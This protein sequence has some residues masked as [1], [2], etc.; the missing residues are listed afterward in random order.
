MPSLLSPWAQS[1]ADTLVLDLH[2]AV[3]EQW[4][5]WRNRSANKRDVVHIVFFNMLE[6]RSAGTDLVHSVFLKHWL[7]Y[8]YWTA[9]LMIG[10]DCVVFDCICFF[11]SFLALDMLV[12]SHLFINSFFWVNF[13]N[14]RTST[15][16]LPRYRCSLRRYWDD[17]EVARPGQK[18]VVGKP[19]YKGAFGC[20]CKGKPGS[21]RPPW[22][23]LVTCTWEIAWAD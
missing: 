3:P 13:E 16:P 17:H 18:T 2:N 1:G 4:Q 15:V 11:L 9:C 23:C 7:Q 14:S 6:D 8:T 5:Q 10:R 12:L 21:N 20:L 22:A 19:A